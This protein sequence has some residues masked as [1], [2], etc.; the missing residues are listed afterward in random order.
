MGRVVIS[1]GSSETGWRKIASP[2]IPFCSR[3]NRYVGK[4]GFLNLQWL[5]ETATE[6]TKERSRASRRPE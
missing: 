5:E 4:T 3:G 6:A 2:R 1:G